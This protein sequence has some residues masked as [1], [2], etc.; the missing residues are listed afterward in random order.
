VQVVDEAVPPVIKYGPRR[1]IIC[2]A[3]VL[4]AFILAVLF[5]LVYTWWRRNYAYYAH[6]LREAADHAE[7]ADH[8]A[9]LPPSERTSSKPF[10]TA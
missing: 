9:S 5:V 1:S 10:T 2:I 8:S 4:S 6:R 7:A 3:A